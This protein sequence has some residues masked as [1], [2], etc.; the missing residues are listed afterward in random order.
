MQFSLLKHIINNKIIHWNDINFN[1]PQYDPIV[2]L[3][4]IK[5]SWFSDWV[6]GFTIAEGSFGIKSNCSAFYSIKQKGIE[7]F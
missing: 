6:I 3:N 4:L 2:S 7:N 1:K 5:L